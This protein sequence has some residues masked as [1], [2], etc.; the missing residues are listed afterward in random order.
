M[1]HCTPLG[2][3]QG[4]QF[5]VDFMRKLTDDYF[6]LSFRFSIQPKLNR[7]HTS[8]YTNTKHKYQV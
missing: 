7:K 4:M 6:N 2:C 1:S 5:T 8:T 3:L